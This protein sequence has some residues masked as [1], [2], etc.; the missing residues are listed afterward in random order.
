MERVGQKKFTGSF[1]FCIQENDYRKEKSSITNA[2][3][4]TVATRNMSNRSRSWRTS[5]VVKQGGTTARK[6]IV[7]PAIPT[8]RLTQ[9]IDEPKRA[10]RLDAAAPA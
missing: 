10:A 3:F 5:G 2:A 1:G 9:F 7:L 8:M 6:R 4:V